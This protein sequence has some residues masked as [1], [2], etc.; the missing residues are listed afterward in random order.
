MNGSLSLAK[1]V[2]IIAGS[3]IGN[4]L[5][6]T[7]LL[8]SLR[9]AHPGLAIDV[10]VPEGRGDILIGNADVRSVLS[11][12]RTAGWHR[13]AQWLA[14]LRN[15]YSCALSTR[16]GDR[17]L[18]HAW[19]AAPFRA[20]HVEQETG[21]HLWVKWAI[22]HRVPLDLSTHAVLHG[23][24]LLEPLGISPDYTLVPP[25]CSPEAREAM[26]RWLP[27]DPATTPYAVVHP[28]ARNRYKN[29]TVAG[30]QAV[31]RHLHGRGLR[32]V[33]T[34]AR[35]GEEERI[36]RAIASGLPRDALLDASSQLSLPQ[37][38][39][40]LRGAAVYAGPDTG[41]THL[42]AATGTS[43]V[44]LFG[45]S[46]FVYW[47]HWP[48]GYTDPTPP[49]VRRGCQR[50]GNVSLVQHPEPCVGCGRE[51]CN[52]DPTEPTR[53]MQ[54]LP[55]EWVLAAIE[56]GLHAS[57]HLTGHQAPVVSHASS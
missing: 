36:L 3:G 46:E 29:W 47:S 10:L 13:Q 5:L 11:A 24:R 41:I 42:A 49:F 12:P 2:L 15:C 1:P 52:D 55:A 40:L 57:H 22:Q 16:S 23:L 33:M 51:G 9:R 27:F 35:V 8:R 26:L 50:V 18:F 43:C 32:T 39:E 28:C 56:Q 20:A 37:I 14:R 7:P 31:V 34:G 44:V 4:I 53:C 45:P 19:L 25:S 30:W 48:V 21:G 54:S 6:A 17:S 38:A